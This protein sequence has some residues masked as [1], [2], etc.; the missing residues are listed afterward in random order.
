MSTRLKIWM[1]FLLL[2]VPGLLTASTAVVAIHRAESLEFCSSCHTMTP[3][4]E[5]V[6]GKESDSLASE[7]Y[8]NRWIQT[9]QCYT[10]HTNYGLFGPV[11]AKIKGVRHV[12]AF[13]VGDTSP[14]KL[15]DPFPNENCL[16]CH[17]EAKGFLE[18][19]NHD[20][21]EDILSGE[22]R[23]VDCHENLHGIEQPGAEDEE[24][25]DA[26]AEDKGD[27]AAETGDGEKAAD[28]AKGEAE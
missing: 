24:A 5:N 9:D 23:C 21:I 15:Y 3:W 18:D 8:K 28:D 14:I 4:V 2:V 11:E 27:A 10:C 22:D 20:P 6:T 1:F 25:D 7:H 13:Y 19:S 26:A 17:R 16:H 12:I